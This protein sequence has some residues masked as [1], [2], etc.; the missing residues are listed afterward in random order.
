MSR[1]AGTSLLAAFA[2]AAV[3]SFSAILFRLSGVTPITGAVYRMVYALPPLFL[4]WFFSRHLDTRPRRDRLVAMVAGALL[5][6]DVVLWHSSIEMIGAGLAT[7]IANSQVVIVPVF[8][9]ILF[10]ERLTRPTILAMPVVMVGLALITGL[11]QAGTYGDRPFLGVA[12]AVGAATLYSGFLIAFRRSHRNLSPPQGPLLDA[13]VGA[14]I[15]AV[16]A[17]MLL[18]D[19][20][21]APTWPAHG[22]LIL[23]ALGTQIVGWLAIG[24]ALPRLPAAHTSFAI[25]L[26]PTLTLLWGAIIFS[27][28]A[29]MTQ[30]AGVALVLA[31]I[32]VVSIY[33]R[34]GQPI[35]V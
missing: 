34:R 2:G 22:W 5:T 27:E 4:L 16:L 23:L 11:G 19:F 33:G 29:S 3:I 13:V 1:P 31:G 15:V 30:G 9:L 7:L 8:T 10:G 14:T 21:L 28:R 17:A 12:L 20:D 35:V 6:A 18:G 25:L 24:Y 32:T 26:Q